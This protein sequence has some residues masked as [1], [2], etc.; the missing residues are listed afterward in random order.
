MP[1]EGEQE[2]Q[3]PFRWRTA[4]NGS[5]N[6]ADAL[7]PVLRQQE[8]HL[9]QS[10]T[11]ADPKSSN[12]HEPK[13][14]EPRL[15]PAQQQR[16]E[17][18]QAQYAQVQGLYEQGES[19][20]TIAK[21]LGIDSNALRY[22]CRTISPGPQRKVEVDASQEKPVSTPICHTSTNAGKLVAR[23]GCSYGERYAHEATLGQLEV[24]DHILLSCVKRLKH[25][26]R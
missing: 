16:R 15:T 2:P 19:L 13:A 12:P 4:G 10:K 9:R 24:A 8:H 25:C 1:K 3:R 17:E 6:V 21:N 18:M 14:L 26:F 20:H 11:S 23:T 22:G 5:R 7:D